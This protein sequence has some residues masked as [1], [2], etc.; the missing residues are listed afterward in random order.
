MTIHPPS[1]PPPVPSPSIDIL[2]RLY[3]PFER[4]KLLK[5][6]W[7]PPTSIGNSFQNRYGNFSG[8]NNPRSLSHSE[9]HWGFRSPLEA[10]LELHSS[11]LEHGDI[12]LAGDIRIDRTAVTA[13]PFVRS[14][15]AKNK[16]RNL[17]D[18]FLICYRCLSVNPDLPSRAR[19]RN[20]NIRRSNTKRNETLRSVTYIAY[21]YI[22][23]EVRNN[24]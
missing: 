19:A 9:S 1:S 20:R 21:I 15:V 5:P 12:R 2:I 3:K 6:W 18:R 10:Y 22:E 24:V 13:R 4:I 16:T 14:F 8:R 11:T 7:T 17:F 23:R